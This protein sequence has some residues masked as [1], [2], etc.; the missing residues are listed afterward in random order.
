MGIWADGQMGRWGYGQ[1]GRWG[2]GDMG[3]YSDFQLDEPQ[4]QNYSPCRDLPWNVSTV[5]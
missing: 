4:S 5:V 1:M 2:Y 3:R